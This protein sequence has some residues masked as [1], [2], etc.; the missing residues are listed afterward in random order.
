MTDATLLAVATEE[1]PK[2][3]VRIPD[4]EWE[5]GL[6]AASDNGESLPLVIRRG[7]ADYVSQSG[8]GFCTEYR[9]TSITNPQTVVTGIEGDLA[10]VRRQFPAKYWRLDSYR[11][12]PYQPIGR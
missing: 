4:S 2:R 9:A 7:I 3:T 1:T 12:S 11:R 8:S 10:D 5:A 6:R